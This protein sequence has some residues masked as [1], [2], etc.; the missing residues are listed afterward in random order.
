MRKICLSALGHKL[1]GYEDIPYYMTSDPL[2]RLHQQ[3]ADGEASEII[4]EDVL[5][6]TEYNQYPNVV[7]SI[8]KK[9]E[10]G[11]TLVLSCSDVYELADNIK[12]RKI[13]VEEINTLLF[14]NPK[15]KSLC[16]HSVLFDLFNKC[17][18][19]IIHKRVEGNKLVITGRRP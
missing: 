16:T 18:I 6:Y 12:D 7:Q 9:L 15:L 5:E 10:H 2:A 11:G 13:T 3:V 14:N 4:A 19:Q 1:N 8:A 17:G